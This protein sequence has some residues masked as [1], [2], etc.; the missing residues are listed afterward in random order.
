MC[1]ISFLTGYFILTTHLPQMMEH[2]MRHTV[3]LTHCKFLILSLAISLIIR[4]LRY[5]GRTGLRVNWD[6]AMS[7]DHTLYSCSHVLQ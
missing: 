5:S 6:S 7:V 4:P 2:V 1:F 3:V